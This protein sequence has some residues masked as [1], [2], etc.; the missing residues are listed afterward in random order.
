MERDRESRIKQAEELTSLQEHV[1]ARCTGSLT[2]LEH[3]NAGPAPQRDPTAVVGTLTPP[4]AW[5]LHTVLAPVPCISLHTADGRVSRRVFSLFLLF[6]LDIRADR[7]E[8]HS[9]GGLHRGVMSYAVCCTLTPV[10]RAIL[11][12]CNVD[13]L[14]DA[15]PRNGR[16]RGY[17]DGSPRGILV[18]SG[19]NHTW[20]GSA[21]VKAGNCLHCLVKVT[22]PSP[23]YASRRHSPISTLTLVGQTQESSSE[24]SV[25]TAPSG[26]V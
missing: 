5:T 16:L 21:T 2:L 19:S 13:D 11:C 1:P 3:Q 18:L 8:T 9:A 23:G 6:L 26:H 4:P 10:P 20:S 17:D 15:W 14:T 25:P 22:L 7:T 24:C 12:F